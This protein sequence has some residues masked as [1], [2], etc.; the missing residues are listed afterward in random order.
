MLLAC[1]KI[2]APSAT[3]PTV[4]RFKDPVCNMW[5]EKK[6]AFYPFLHDGV[7]YYFCCNDCVLTFSKD[8][9][10]YAYKCECKKVQRDCKCDHCA[11]KQV[12]CDCR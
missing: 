9:V 6:A 8:T 7:L 5:V 12:P 11:G 3:R 2:P 10:K 1:G 4:E